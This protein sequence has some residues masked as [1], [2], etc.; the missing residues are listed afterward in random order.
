MSE[1]R[2]TSAVHDAAERLPVFLR[3]DFVVVF[4]VEGYCHG[5]VGADGGVFVEAAGKG[6]GIIM[7]FVVVAAHEVLCGKGGH[8]A[9]DGVVAGGVVRG[10]HLVVVGEVHF[11]DVLLGFVG[12]LRIV[13]GAECLSPEVSGAL[14]LKQISHFAV[15]ELLLGYLLALRRAAGVEVVAVVEGCG[16]AVVS[17]IYKGS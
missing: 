5:L 6:D 2:S 14:V 15:P 16:Y 9:V 1:P 17:V 7:V 12:G 3:G 8:V 13:L 4:F 11:A 10:F